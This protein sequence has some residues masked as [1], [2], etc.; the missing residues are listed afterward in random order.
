MVSY[1]NLRII[2]LRLQV[3][4]TNEKLFGDI[5]VLLLYDVNVNVLQ[6]KD[7]GVLYKHS[8]WCA[9][10]I[11]LWYQFAFRE[12]TINMRQKYDT[13]FIDLLII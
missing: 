7:I 11:N 6:Q 13:E 12:L 9:A 1:E 5:N 2:H 8:L 10:K 4:K 3:Y